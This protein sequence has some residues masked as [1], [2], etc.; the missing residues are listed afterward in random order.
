MF[1]TK[2]LIPELR[3][4][5]GWRDHYDVLEVPALSAPL[6]ISL[7][8]EYFQDYHPVCDLKIVNA[9]KPDNQTMENYLD[10]KTNAAILQMCNEIILRKRRAEVTKGIISDTELIDE[11]ASPSDTIT[12]EGRFVGIAFKVLNTIGLKAQIKRFSLNLTTN[13]TLT[14]YLY[15]SSQKEALDTFSVVTENVPK[16]AWFSDKIINLEARNSAISGGIYYLGYYEEDL[17]GQALN[18]KEYDFEHWNCT[19]CNQRSDRKLSMG[20]IVENVEA[21]PFYC[22]DFTKLELPDPENIIIDYKYTWGLNVSMNLICD[23]TQFL[24]DNAT[25][26]KNLIGKSVVY[27]ILKDAQYSQN[28]N[29]IEENVRL[30]IIRDL[31]GAKDSNYVNIADQLENE[32][33]AVTYDQSSLS[34]ICLASVAYHTP[35]YRQA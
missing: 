16:I 1:D 9:I 6:K 24:I 29:F 4:Q 3:K 31:E 15:H 33:I 25:S 35:K 30:M 34:R 14:V 20:Q 13:Q 18:V 5:I 27:A 12:S 26:I 23:Y 2:V 17:T 11:V 22:S 28:L 10:T 32:F 19:S 7:T 21:M 8:G